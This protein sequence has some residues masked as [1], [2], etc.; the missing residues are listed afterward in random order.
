MSG[1]NFSAGNQIKVIKK[2]LTQTEV[3]NLDTTP[4]QLINWLNDVNFIN[5]IP[6]AI[7]LSNPVASR[8]D[9][10]N[11]IFI[12]SDAVGKVIAYLEPDVD[13]LSYG[14]NYNFLLNGAAGS[15]TV[16][17]NDAL[18]IAATN[19]GSPI[20]A[21]GTGDIEIIILYFNF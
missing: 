2:T 6:L 11:S 9:N 12:Q 1:I 21:S 13:Q 8:I 4:I 15:Q 19:N 7:S 10:I 16:K 18:T 5:W 20:T 17:F 14:T 3:T